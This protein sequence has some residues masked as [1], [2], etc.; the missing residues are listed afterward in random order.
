MKHHTNFTLG[1][2]KEMLSGKLEPSGD[3]CLVPSVIRERC[4]DSRIYIL[5]QFV[6]LWRSQKGTLVHYVG[7]SSGSSNSGS[8]RNNMW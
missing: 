5:R 8:N 3:D 2:F 6:P 7:G 1:L 4:R